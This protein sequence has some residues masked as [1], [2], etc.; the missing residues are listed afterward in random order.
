MIKKKPL[1]TKE[2]ELFLN[3]AKEATF[4]RI[5]AEFLA[6]VCFDFPEKSGSIKR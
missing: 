2:K 3:K 5:Q 1:K 4:S 6:K